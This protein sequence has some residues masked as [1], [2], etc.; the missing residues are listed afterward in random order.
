MGILFGLIREMTRWDIPSKIAL[1]INLI[2]LVIALAIASTQPDL[3]TPST[4]AIVGLVISLQVIVMWGNRNLVAPYTQAQRHFLAGEFEQARDVLEGFIDDQQT[5]RKNIDVDVFVV[6]GNTYRNLGKL[7]RSE[8]TLNI[9]LNNRPNYHFALYGIG[10]TLLA[11][12]NY[13]GAIDAFTETLEQGGYLTTYIDLAH[14][15]YL[16]GHQEHVAPLLETAYEREQQGHTTGELH[17]LHRDLLSQYLLWKVGEAQAPDD[18]YIIRAGIEFLEAE[19]QRFAH[20]P[21]GQAVS[22]QVDELRSLL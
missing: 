14:A 12:G 3:R 19:A 9:A 10:K 16:A 7:D 21:Y 17:E 8:N 15:N 6:L 1:A 4:V 22:K 5:Q 2:L 20:T 11:S 18:G 13:Q